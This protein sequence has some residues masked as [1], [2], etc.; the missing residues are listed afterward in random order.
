MTLTV[1]ERSELTQQLVL[2]TDRI[3]CDRDRLVMLTKV[4]RDSAEPISGADTDLVLLEREELR[5]RRIEGTTELLSQT[6]RAI[7]QNEASRAS[8]EARLG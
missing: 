1:T 3:R 4:I 5:I 6:Q 7:E 8:L 2:L